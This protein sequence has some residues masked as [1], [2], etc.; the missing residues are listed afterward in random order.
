[1]IGY[2]A[3]DLYLF[4]CCWERVS[5][6][7]TCK[8]FLHLAPSNWRRSVLN[9]IMQCNFVSQSSYLPQSQRFF[10]GLPSSA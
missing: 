3:F 8:P 5:L 6:R 1:M 4:F 2:G 9:A 7:Y 10:S